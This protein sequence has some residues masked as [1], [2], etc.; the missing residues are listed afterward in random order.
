MGAT[1]TKA[2]KS[3]QPVRS[4]ASKSRLSPKAQR[5]IVAATG[6]PDYSEIQEMFETAVQKLEQWEKSGA[7]D[8]SRSRYWS[9]VHQALGWVVGQLSENP[10]QAE[11]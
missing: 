1:K 5:K 6:K 2:P 7:P 9:G 11:E 3:K 4:S 8:T 10:V